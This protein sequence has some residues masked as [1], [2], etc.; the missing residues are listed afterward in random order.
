MANRKGG[1]YGYNYGNPYGGGSNAYT[2]DKIITRRSPFSKPFVDYSKG[3]GSRMMGWF[4]IHKE[5]F[6]EIDETIATNKADFAKHMEEAQNLAIYE[7][8]NVQGHQLDGSTWGGQDVA[9]EAADLKGLIQDY[10]GA[11]LKSRGITEKK[12]FDKDGNLKRT[13]LVGWAK[14]TDTSVEGINARAEAAQIKGYITKAGKQKTLYKELQ[15][16]LYNDESELDIISAHNDENQVIEYKK[17]MDPRNKTRYDKK[18]NLI[19]IAEDGT[20]KHMSELANMQPELRNAELPEVVNKAANAVITNKTG[21]YITASTD[22][23]SGET[24][25]SVNQNMISAEYDARFRN[26]TDADFRDLSINGGQEVINEDGSV[27]TSNHW[28]SDESQIMQLMYQAGFENSK[29]NPNDVNHGLTSGRDEKG[30]IPEL[31]QEYIKHNKEIDKKIDAL[32]KNDPNYK[33]QRKE[34]LDQWKSVDPTHGMKRK[35][36]NDHNFILDKNVWVEGS[37]ARNELIASLQDGGVDQDDLNKVVNYLNSY[38]DPSGAHKSMPISNFLEHSVKRFYKD[39][40]IKLVQNNLDKNQA[41]ALADR[42]AKRIAHEYAYDLKHGK[43]ESWK[44]LM[45]VQNTLGNDPTNVSIDRI[46]NM[47]SGLK[48]EKGENWYKI[49][50]QDPNDPNKWVLAPNYTGEERTLQGSMKLRFSVQKP[51]QQT[52]TSADPT[53]VTKEGASAGKT[54][55]K[56]GDKNAVKYQD[57]TWDYTWDGNL[58]EL[59]V[60]MSNFIGDAKVIHPGLKYSGNRINLGLPGSN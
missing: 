15:D 18:G 28:N 44:N 17:F 36:F 27:T 58:D 40:A 16:A 48:S 8:G 26:L 53:V 25:Y 3:M 7:G 13:K 20:E 59:K 19:I 2:G 41:A 45:L 6:D 22:P 29:S 50:I 1:G 34:L 60:Q 33:Q 55:T 39:N 14:K 47:M 21:K 49:E 38:K 31:K 11:W 10:R 46:S 54:T 5:H 37:E 43:D 42:T 23:V 35:W 56:P 30:G 9:G 24:S 12:K 4:K 32:D 57:L 51:E 52:T